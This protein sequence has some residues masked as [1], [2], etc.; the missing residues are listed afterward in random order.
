[1]FCGEPMDFLDIAMSNGRK[2]EQKT[3]SKCF[4]KEIARKDQMVIEEIHSKMKDGRAILHK[5]RVEQFANASSVSSDIPSA[6]PT[7]TSCS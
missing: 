2:D 3:C 6:S 1:M 4:L 5:T 7:D